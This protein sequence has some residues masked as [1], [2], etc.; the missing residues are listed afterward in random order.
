MRRGS[1]IEGMAQAAQSRRPQSDSD[2][3]EDEEWDD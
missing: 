3:G 1:G 2:S